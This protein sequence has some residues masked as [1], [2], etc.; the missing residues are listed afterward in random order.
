MAFGPRRTARR[1]PVPRCCR[2]TPRCPPRR[3]R[4]RRRS[5]ARCRIETAEPRS[6]PP[7]PRGRGRRLEGT[8]SRPI[9][10][11]WLVLRRIA[12]GVH[13]PYWDR[14]DDALHVRRSCASSRRCPPPGRT[15]RRPAPCGSGRS[16]RSTPARS[17]AA[18]PLEL[19]HRG[20]DGRGAAGEDLDDVA[21][22]HAS[23][24][25]S[26]EIL[27]SS[28]W[29]PIFPASSMIEPRVM[30]SRMVPSAGVTIRPSL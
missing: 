20:D 23:R 30:P 9:R 25:S 24:H 19:A 6:A 1:P 12:G 22:G 29:W 13:S 21:A 28:T 7:P 16:A 4:R 14:A 5:A 18:L 26:I 3:G 10:S 2:T 11:S 15:A 8:G 27:R 17:R